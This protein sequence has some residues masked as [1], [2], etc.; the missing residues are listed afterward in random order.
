MRIEHGFIESAD[1]TDDELDVWSACCRAFA[2]LTTSGHQDP[3]G[4]TLVLSLSLS[5][6]LASFS[7]R[8][9]LERRVKNQNF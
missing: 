1:L 5:L 9:K 2:S 6:V 8:T 7:F 4:L 3:V